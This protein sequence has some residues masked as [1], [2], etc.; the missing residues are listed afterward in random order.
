MTVDELCDLGRAFLAVGRTGTVTLWTDRERYAELVRDCEARSGRSL[1][2]I[3]RVE[4]GFPDG[5][6]VVVPAYGKGEP[7]DHMLHPRRGLH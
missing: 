7:L 3:P 1:V 2:A 4:V 6:I 5:K